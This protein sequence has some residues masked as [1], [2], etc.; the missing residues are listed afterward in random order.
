[1]TTARPVILLL[2]WH[3]VFRSLTPLRPLPMAADDVGKRS[4]EFWLT[5]RQIPSKC[6]F[7]SG[8]DALIVRR[9]AIDGRIPSKARCSKGKTPTITAELEPNLARDTKTALG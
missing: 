3:D 5:E 2:H 6:L 9:D 8:G 1:M 7:Q 4:S